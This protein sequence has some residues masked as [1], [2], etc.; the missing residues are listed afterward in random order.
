MRVGMR[1][2]FQPALALLLLAC[3]TAPVLELASA[4]ADDASDVVDATSSNS[5]GDAPAFRPAIDPAPSCEERIAARALDAPSARHEA[6]FR[7]LPEVLVHARIDPV[8]YLSWPD[9][10]ASDEEAQ[11][12]RD[13][14]AHSA[15]PLRD[16]RRLLDTNDDPAFLRAVLLSDGYLFSD[17]PALALAL[18]AE[19]RLTHLFDAP[20]LVRSRDGVIEVLVLD[21]EGYLEADGSV[22]RL[23]LNDRVSEDPS[24]LAS[25]RTLDL[26][27]VREQTGALRTSPTGLGSDAAAF[28]LAFPD[29]TRRP[30]LVE[31]R[32]GAT[33]VVCVGGSMET[34]QS[35]LAHAAR[36]WAR[37]AGVTAAARALVRENARFDEPVN[38]PEGVQEDGVLRRAWT[39]AYLRGARTFTHREVEYPVFD[40]EGRA[41]P[42]QVCVDFVFDAWERGGGTWYRGADAS[43]G[44]DA[45]TIDFGQTASPSAGA[46]PRRSIAQL[47]EYARND[48]AVLERFDVPRRERVALHEGG[49]YA[50]AL[51]RTADAFREGDALIIHGLR[52]Q[53]MRLHY[54]AVLVI[55]TE[56]VTGVPMVVADN[57]GRPRLRTLVGA[58]RAAPLRSI[59]HRLRVDVNAL[60]A[61]TAGAPSAERVAGG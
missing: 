30:S 31:L 38:E 11:A 27:V 14:L 61:L 4:P 9:E 23:R 49:A 44:R 19:V 52:E 55:R 35:T 51:A 57:Q 32:D 15:H 1:T 8:L 50:R 36:F 53:D 25:P 43:P 47:L 12:A 56:P 54:H 28:E 2:F 39:E 48:D 17:R 41:I 40:S 10:D 18:S 29:G 6:Y 45:G 26:D 60:S 37:H 34:L 21:D 16:L 59:D 46:V 42:P 3:G 22:A 13:A 33:E 7:R 58:M 24:V 20:H 5:G